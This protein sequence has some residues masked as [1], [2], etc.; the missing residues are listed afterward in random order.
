VPPLTCRHRDGT[1]YVRYA[2]IEEEICCARAA[3]PNTWNAPSLTCEALVHLIRALRKRLGFTDAISR[4]FDQL[5]RR[6]AVITG[7][8][9]RGFSQSER[10][11]IAEEVRHRVLLLVLAEAPTPK[12]E[13]LEVVFDRAV[14]GLT[15]NIVRLRR[16]R[17]CTQQFAP[18]VGK[19]GEDGPGNADQSAALVDPGPEPEEFV[20][21]EEER[22]LLLEQ[23]ERVSDPRHREAVILR[24]YGGW[25]IRDDDPT[26]PTLCKHFGVTAHT[27]NN[28]I[29][30]A[31]A[32]I[33]EATGE[34]S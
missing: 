24:F 27:I 3:D 16:Q 34:K 9:S 13:F 7:D 15:I 1:P 18:L 12:S 26:K 4:L 23:V 2:D 33:K 5:G 6:V 28:W 10:E 22:A 14:Q 32:Q 20:L 19:D 8:Y 25:Q 21:K 30:G 29:R 31:L 11:E 17:P